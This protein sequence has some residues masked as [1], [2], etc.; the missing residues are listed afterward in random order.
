MKTVVFLITLLVPLCSSCQSPTA[1]V[2]SNPDNVPVPRE[3]AEEDYI[4]LVQGLKYYDFKVGTGDSVKIGNI[5]SVH[6]H[7][8]LTDSTLFDTS[9]LRQEPFMFRLGS[10]V[11]IPGWDLGI[12]E[13][14]PGGERQLVISPELAY[15]EQGR[16][17]IPPNATLIFEVILVSAN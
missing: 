13:M 2:P 7:G 1:P 12:P 17:R 16:G 11:V 10:G 3:V 8:W 15:G 9:Y 4:E 14:Q 6:Y 5:V